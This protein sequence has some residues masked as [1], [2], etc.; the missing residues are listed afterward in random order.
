VLVAHTLDQRVIDVDGHG[1]FVRE[2]GAP[3]AVPLV[4][5]HGLVVSGTYLVPT[6]RLLARDR[7]VVVPDLPGFGRSHR[8]GARTPTV[9]D[10]STALARILDALHIERADLLGQS[11]GSQVVADFALCFP[12]RVRK[13]VLVS[14]THDDHVL[15][16]PRWLVDGPREKPMLTAIIAADYARAGFVRSIATMRA[17]VKDDPIPKL[18]RIR[19]DALVVRGARDPVVTQG[20]A[21]RIAHALPRGRLVVIPGAPHAINYTT[22][23][24]LARVTQAFLAERRA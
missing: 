1:V 22:P 19:A 16:F 4:M 23:L 9:A 5:V 13:L 17:M 11:F 2:A 20:F 15:S 21:E 18:A 24:E 3:S 14:P 7:R 6:A 12:D 10:L 8:H